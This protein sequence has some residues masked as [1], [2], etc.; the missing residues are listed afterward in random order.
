MTKAELL[1][2]ARLVLGDVAT[3]YLW[4]D[5]ELTSYLEDAE[6][7]AAER[8]DLIE[9]DGVETYCTVA[10]VAETPTYQLSPLVY[11]VE[12]ARIAGEGQFLKRTS[13]DKLDSTSPV[14][15]DESGT[16]REYYLTG[17]ALRL[18]PN[19]SAEGTLNLVVLRLPVAPMGTSP[20]IN[21]RHHRRM[22]DWVY[23]QAFLKRDA[24][25]YNETES[26]KYERMFAA[27]F[28]E[29]KDAKLSTRQLKHTPI[30]MR[31]EW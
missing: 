6:K 4:S 27:S 10:V 19:P 9:A 26:L 14:W 23:R 17:N 8:A 13:R 31:D 18:V 15:E 28:G 29:R 24:D 22:L 12:R 7:E 11:E 5:L 20:E 25:T 30:E 21:V 3:P 2:A 1:A 16:P